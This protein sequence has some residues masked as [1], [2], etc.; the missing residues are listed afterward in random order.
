MNKVLEDALAR[1]RDLPPERQGEAGE[2][3]LCVVEG[4]RRGA[5][6][7][8]PAQI[9]EAKAGIAELDAG[10]TVAAEE[11]LRGLRKITG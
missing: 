5:P 1:V 11:A 3:I 7:L 6:V 2:I 8:T 4:L 10:E 9:E